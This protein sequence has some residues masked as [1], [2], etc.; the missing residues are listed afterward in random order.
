M[1]HPSGLVT[2]GRAL[3]K[4]FVRKYRARD[5]AP[6]GLTVLS[7]RQPYFNGQVG[8]N[9]VTQEGNHQILLMM[10]GAPTTPPGYFA[11][12]NTFLG[13]S[14]N[15]A[16]PLR[17]DEGIGGSNI[18]WY[19]ALPR[20]VEVSDGEYVIQS[21]TGFGSSDANWLWAR[22]SLCLYDDSGQPP[23]DDTVAD[24]INIGVASLSAGIKPAGEIWILT[25]RFSIH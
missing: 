2:R 3:H 10:C 1:K 15:E 20:V 5:V 24:C 13:V 22:A 16:A 8:Q 11:D 7:G 18:K 9:L 23:A 21:S 6:D 25:S 14:D 4:F 17:S 12:D 19:D